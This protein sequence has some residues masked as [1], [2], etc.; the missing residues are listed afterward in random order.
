MSV[1]IVG[2]GCGKFGG[3][4]GA[5]HSRGAG[6][7]AARRGAAIDTKRCELPDATC[8]R[9][10]RVGN[11]LGVCGVG[12]RGGGRCGGGVGRGGVLQGGSGGGGALRCVGGGSGGKLSGRVGSIV[13]VGVGVD[14]DE[15]MWMRRL[16]T[17][18]IV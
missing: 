10:L 9:E 5:G 6:R 8:R 15:V 11:E 18:L 17:K 12:A 3:A 7:G 13:G 4:V 2:G 16:Q 14:D 1:G